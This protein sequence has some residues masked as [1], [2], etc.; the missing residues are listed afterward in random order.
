MGGQNTKEFSQESEDE[1]IFD[2]SQRTQR[3]LG[4]IRK[5][6]LSRD[7][8]YIAYNDIVGENI[9]DHIKQCVYWHRTKPFLPDKKTVK[10]VLISHHQP[11]TVPPPSVFKFF[12]VAYNN[13]SEIDSFSGDPNENDYISQSG[14]IFY[15]PSEQFW[16]AHCSIN[17]RQDDIIKCNVI[18]E[19][20][21]FTDL[22][23]N[24]FS[25]VCGVVFTDGTFRILNQRDYELECLW[26]E[27]KVIKS[28]DFN[29]RKTL[30]KNL[31][32]NS[33]ETSTVLDILTVYIKKIFMKIGVNI[34]QDEDEYI[35]DILDAFMKSSN[36]SLYMF[37]EK[38]LAILIFADIDGPFGKYTLSFRKRFALKYY[39]AISLPELHTQDI[40]PEFYLKLQE[41]SKSMTRVRTYINEYLEQ[42][43]DIIISESV[44][45]IS[46]DLKHKHFA[47]IMQIPLNDLSQSAYRTSDLC[48]DRINEH[49]SKSENEDIIIFKNT[50]NEIFCYN[51]FDV[52]DMDENT[53]RNPYTDENDNLFNEFIRKTHREFKHLKRKL[54]QQERDDALNMRK[55]PVKKE[56]Q[57]NTQ[58]ERTKF[59]RNEFVPN[60]R[61][62]S[63]SSNEEGLFD[64]SEGDE[65][66]NNRML[67]NIF[68]DQEEVDSENEDRYTPRLSSISEGGN[69]DRY[70]PRL[71]TIPEGGNEDRYKP[72]LSTISEGG[73]EDRYKPRL[74]TISEGGNEDRYKPR[75]STISEDDDD[76]FK[77]ISNN[78]NEENDKCAVCTGKV[79]HR[80]ARLRE[81]RRGLKG[82]I[83]NV[84]SEQCANEL[85]DVTTVFYDEDDLEDIKKEYTTRCY[86]DI[87][88][89][90]TKLENEIVIAN[91]EHEAEID[92]LNKDIE[93]EKNRL[94]AELKDSYEKGSD[95]DDIK[96]FY[97]NEKQKW[98]QEL[99]KCRDSYTSYKNRMND[100][101]NNLKQ[102]TEKIKNEVQQTVLDE[103]KSKVEE[104]Q[105][106]LTKQKN[107]IKGIDNTYNKI[108]TNHKIPFMNRQKEI[109]EIFKEPDTPDK[110]DYKNTPILDSISD[111]NENIKY[112]PSLDTIYESDEESDRYSDEESDKYSDEES[113]KYSDEETKNK[114]T[115]RKYKPDLDTIYESEEDDNET[116]QFKIKPK[117]SRDE[118]NKMRDDEFFNQPTRPRERVENQSFKINRKP[119]KDELNRIR[120]NE[121]N[122]YNETKRKREE[123]DLQKIKDQEEEES[124]KRKIKDQQIRQQ[125]YDDLQK[126]LVLQREREEK[127]KQKRQQDELLEK[128]L[129]RESDRRESE[130]EN[131]RQRDNLRRTDEE[132]KRKYDK[133]TEEESFKNK[134]LESLS[135]I[136]RDIQN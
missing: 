108:I 40:F 9:P 106:N 103:W 24:S 114:S 59:P 109:E 20:F 81:G 127:N 69:E 75:L 36:N 98:E 41:D 94:M 133:R 19:V 45:K 43:I 135:Q 73:N 60:L 58:G 95:R 54:T 115:S 62:I 48:H 72:R 10:Y 87:K 118:L 83:R 107:V 50:D 128:T 68:G 92:K 67:N 88:Y 29:T 23:D 123:Y 130:L 65:S 37:I 102:N 70:K 105:D 11:N 84:C 122:N 14:Y 101:I 71:S 35:K 80:L 21:T 89:A 121:K 34:Q 125:K 97:E 25:F 78:D 33:K 129:R 38:I 28:E 120:E 32:L 47:P 104:C 136:G 99:K 113:D 77:T 90:T 79:L 76:I 17:H 66:D 86:E 117:P 30:F 132:N 26:W 22:D 52:L 49:V 18:D 1:I 112:K 5:D 64:I 27:N 116:R 2:Q 51:I 131:E 6:I 53:L 4:N 61:T 46:P 3:R 100:D 63:E 12:D 16:A 82:E 124:R 31:P 85:D 96:N 57:D 74:S 55:G 93:V 134:F 119:S 8:T 7:D 126:S 110:N 13:E 44:S 111:E 42:K 39:S 15:Y 56:M 91:N